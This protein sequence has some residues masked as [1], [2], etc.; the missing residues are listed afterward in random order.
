MK[1]RWWLSFGFVDQFAD[2]VL[3]D[4]VPLL[5]A[6]DSDPVKLKKVAKQQQQRD[7]ALAILRK[8]VAEFAFREKPNFFQKARLSKRLQDGLIRGG[9]SPEFARDMAVGIISKLV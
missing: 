1:M 2:S 3:Q 9:A 7:V 8:R 6:P 5:R 4:V